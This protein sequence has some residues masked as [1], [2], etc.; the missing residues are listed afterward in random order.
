M[1]VPPEAI[2]DVKALTLWDVVARDFLDLAA[3]LGC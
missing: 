3:R 1:S 2:M